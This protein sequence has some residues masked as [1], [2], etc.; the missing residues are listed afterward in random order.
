[1]LKTRARTVSSTS[2]PRLPQ[3]MLLA[4]RRGS[5]NKKW[6]NALRIGIILETN[7]KITTGVGNREGAEE[8]R[9]LGLG[10]EVGPE[11]VFWPFDE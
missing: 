9:E 7:R 11:I 8:K 4:P 6:E 1:M 5:R 3:N 2:L 10:G